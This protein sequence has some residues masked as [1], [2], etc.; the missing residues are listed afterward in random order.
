MADP[1]H[2]MCIDCGNTI[3]PGDEEYDPETEEGPLCPTCLEDRGT[4]TNFDFGE[5]DEFED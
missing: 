1:G 5:S 4:D 3:P 2:R